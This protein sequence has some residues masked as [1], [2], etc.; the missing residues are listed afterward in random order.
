M[1]VNLNADGI[2]SCL[3][4]VHL[5]PPSSLGIISHS[6]HAISDAQE[7]MLHTAECLARLLRTCAPETPYTDEELK[8][9]DMVLTG[10]CHEMDDGNGQDRK[11][12]DE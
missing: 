2:P 5:T 1:E 6:V 7:V 3:Q 10:F 4:I 11:E 12:G 9:G 8:V